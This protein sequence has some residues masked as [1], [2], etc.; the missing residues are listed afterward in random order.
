VFLADQIICLN[1]TNPQLA[2]RLLTPLTTWRRHDD[3]R[4]ALM[5][6]QLERIK[7]QPALSKDVYEVVSKSLA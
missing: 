7:A 5:K 6:T 2:A 1:Q 4:Q 3:H